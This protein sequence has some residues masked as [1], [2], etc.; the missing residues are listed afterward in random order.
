MKVSD[1]IE[2]LRQVPADLRAVVNGYEEGYDDLS[3]E[4]I[5]TAKISLNTGRRRWE[6]RHGDSRDLTKRRPESLDMVDALVL[7]RVSP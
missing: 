4:Q 6:G 1:L 5:S 2:V 7:Q 3:P